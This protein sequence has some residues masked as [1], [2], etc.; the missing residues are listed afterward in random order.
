MANIKIYYL[1][2]N[3]NSFGEEFLYRERDLYNDQYFYTKCPV[4][5]HK[6]NRT[7]VGFSPIDFTIQIDRT[8]NLV[9]CDNEEYVKYDMDQLYSPNPVLQ[10]TFPRFLFWTDESN[11]WFEYRDHPMTSL[12]NNMIG[13]EGWFNLSNWPRNHSNGVTVID[14]KKPVI[15]KK[16]DPLFRVCFYP[17]NLNSGIILEKITDSQKVNKILDHYHQ[18]FKTRSSWKTRLFSKTDIKTCP[19]KFLYDR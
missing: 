17:P 3:C 8:K 11:V 12:N 1:D 10:F 4:F 14:E 7:F 15:I 18:N 13:V 5:N 6:S 19:F 16:G 2:C 9:T